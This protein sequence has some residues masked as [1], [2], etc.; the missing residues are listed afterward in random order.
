MIINSLLP[1]TSL[2]SPVSG[3]WYI[4]TTDPKLG[5]VPVDRKY[6]WEE[7]D[8]MWRKVTY[9]TSI[10]RRAPKKVYIRKAYKVD[11][12]RGNVYNVLNDGGNWN[13]SCPAYGWGRGIECKHIKNIKNTL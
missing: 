11:G 5:W 6:E 2:Q 3:Q 13:C 4:V 9:G 1:P 7:L 12:S 10:A 8:K